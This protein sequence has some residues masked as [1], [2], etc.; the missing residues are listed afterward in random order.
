MADGSFWTSLVG[1]RLFRSDRL[2]Y[3]RVISS[4]EA[5]LVERHWEKPRIASIW[6][7]GG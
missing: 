3:K 5:P 7:V 6:I 2:S 1:I 4:G